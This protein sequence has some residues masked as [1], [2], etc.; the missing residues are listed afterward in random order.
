MFHDL[1]IFFI[2]ISP[3]LPLLNVKLMIKDELRTS[4][5]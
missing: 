2:I 1:L 4:I 3:N 5:V